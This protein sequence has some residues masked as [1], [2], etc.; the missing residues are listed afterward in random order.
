MG[1]GIVSEF[2]VPLIDHHCHGVVPVELSA[3]RFE[4]L[5]SES[6]AP[7]PL[8]TSHWDKPIGLAIRRWCAPVLD[9]SAF[10]SGDEYVTRRAELGAEEVNRRFLSG[11]GLEMLV[12]DSG[13]RPDEL[14]SVEAMG[15][16]AGVPSREV[17]RIESVAEAIVGRGGVSAK[18]YA[19][20]V[21]RA[22]E[23]SIHDRVVGLKSI[24]AYRCT[25]DIDYTRPSSF[26]VFDAA[27]NWLAEVERS[28]KTR[29]TDAVLER[30]LL[31]TAVEIA[32]GKGFPIQL[33]IGI[34]DPDIQLNKVDPSH[35]SPF[36]RAVEPWK[37]NFTLLHCYP[38]HRN[39]GL[40]AENFPHVYFDVGF[41]LNWAGPSYARIIEEAMEIAP[42]TKQLYSSDAFGLAE[43]YYLGALRFR[44]GL[45]R[46]LDHWISEDE[47]KTSE[48]ER[49]MGL[50]ARDNARRIYPSR[51]D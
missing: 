22:L 9:L 30:H 39:A 19:Q 11:A 25:L 12:V 35:L 37:V 50:I 3:D 5:I 1:S 41:V 8:R 23:D 10:C 15:E 45:R 49:I 4:D 42:F 20:S 48:A 17:V 46:V 38:F 31:W 43:L 24:I 27:G 29:V 44:T 26:E 47:C 13:N 14:C 2:S 18:D 40:M 7:A 34:G 6:F 32:K 51:V 21:E 33:H 28:G 36:F 16:I